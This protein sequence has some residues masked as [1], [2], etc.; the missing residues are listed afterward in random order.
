MDLFEH[1]L[2][3]GQNFIDRQPILALALGAALAAV[4]F[5]ALWRAQENQQPNATNHPWL[6]IGRQLAHVAWAVVLVGFLIGTAMALKSYLNGEME[7]F[8]RTHGRV[9]EAN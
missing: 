8:R 5:T 7:Q 2:S 3:H 1:F 4:I 9:S 6:A